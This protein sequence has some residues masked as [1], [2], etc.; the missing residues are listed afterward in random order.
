MSIRRRH[1]KKSN[2]TLILMLLITIVIGAVLILWNP[3]EAKAQQRPTPE[4][5]TIVKDGMVVGCHFGF[6]SL[7]AK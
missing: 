3:T 7:F 5:A 1:Q 6:S 4:Q 2:L